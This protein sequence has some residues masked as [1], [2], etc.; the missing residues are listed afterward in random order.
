M[1]EQIDSDHD[2]ERLTCVLFTLHDS[3]FAVDAMVVRHIIRLPAL[4]SIKGM[5]SWVVGVFDLGG[6]IIPVIDLDLRFGH[7]PH[8]C[9]ISDNVIV[10][11]TDGRMFGFIASRTVDV[12][13]V[14]KMEMAGQA[15]ESGQG[16][17]LLLQGEVEGDGDIVMLLNHS[18]IQPPLKGIS[19]QDEYLDEEL[20]QQPCFSSMATPE[21]MEIL[22]ERAKS[23]K[24]IGM[25]EETADRE[26]FAV[27]EFSGEFFA[28][29]LKI[30]REFA[31]ITDAAPIPCSPSHI[32]GNMNL[33][34]D[35]VTL[36]D[37]RSALSM[38]ISGLKDSGKIVVTERDNLLVGV[39]VKRVLD[40]FFAAD[41]EFK[42]VPTAVREKNGEYV[43]GEIY[44]D[45]KMVTVLDI[46]TLLEQQELIVD[47]EVL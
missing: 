5:V 42:R 29:E 2:G 1:N 6:R 36:V 20:T 38:P 13:T 28:V 24:K 19:L 27:V 22:G 21:E 43:K 11:E 33:R 25:E 47:E 15:E 37:I 23:L 10:V 30:V 26:S 31:N 12:R 18:R 14:K 32:A 35:I 46:A 16:Q 3:L 40:V 17:E 34:G 9:S 41:S 4:T 44:Y 8:P 45:G 7:K 39:L